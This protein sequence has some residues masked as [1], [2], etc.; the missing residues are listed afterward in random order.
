MPS[1]DDLR[2]VREI[3]RE[4]VAALRMSPR[5]IEDRL[6]LG[7][8][9]LK[10]VLDG[11]IDLRVRHLLALSR[12]LDVHPKSFLELG[13]PDWP[14]RHQLQEWMPPSLRKAAK[15]AGVSAEL[16]NAIRSVVREEISREPENPKKRS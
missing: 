5:E 2:G 12:L 10:R 14:A 16:L 3:L 13:L 11:E 6:G 7:H 8:G 15:N 9:T 4:A 1:T